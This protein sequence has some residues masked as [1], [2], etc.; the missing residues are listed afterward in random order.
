MI[1]KTRRIVC[2]VGASVCLPPR[3]LMMR[4]SG[5]TGALARSTAHMTRRFHSSHFSLKALLQAFL[6]GKN[7]PPAGWDGRF[8]LLALLY[9]AVV[10]TIW[11]IIPYA[12]IHPKL[13]IYSAMAFGWL[14]Q[15]RKAKLR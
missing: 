14:L 9:F 10:A 11:A 1:A 6:W 8:L 3:K 12:P 7:G 5:A 2:F 15:R 4:S 13:F